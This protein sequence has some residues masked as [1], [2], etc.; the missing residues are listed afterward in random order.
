MFG[1][2]LIKLRGDACW[3]DLTCMQYHYETQPVPN[4][5]SWYF[6][7][8]PVILHKASVLFNHFV[9]LIAPFGLFIP[10]RIGWA[11]GFLTIIFQIILIL[12]GN[13]S[14]LNYLTI[15]LCLCCFDDR[16]L[17]RFIPIQIPATKPAGGIRKGILNTVSVLLVILSIQPAVNLFSPRQLMNASFDP[18]HVVNTYG[19]F[20]SITQQRNE[21]VL[22]GTSDAVLGPETRWQA[23]EFKCKPGDMDRIPCLMSPYHYRLD[24]LMWFAAMSD[25][26]HHPWIL[27]LIAK[28]L[29][30]NPSTLSLLKTRP[31]PDSPPKFI[32][33]QYYRYRFTDSGEKKKTG[34]HWKREKL[35][36]Y[37]PPLSLDHPEFRKTLEDQKWL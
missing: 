11:A 12:S 32:R 5:L 36:D 29:Q 8:L 1:A 25:Y 6:H 16:I 18:L 21:I 27:N 22:E 19:A 10:G 35:G 4:P 3:Q 24:W 26:R 15:T 31:F 13:L 28:L 33:A 34:R 7:Y 37:L 17:K 23:Y 2:G 30:N 14:W 20:G 9:E